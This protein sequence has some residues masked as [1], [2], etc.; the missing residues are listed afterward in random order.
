MKK[1]VLETAEFVE[2]GESKPTK[3]CYRQQ[4][5]MVL[6]TPENPQ[7]ADYEEMSKTLPMRKKF[8]D[9]KPGDAV[10][11][12]DAEHELLARR[13]KNARFG[14]NHDELFAMVASIVDAP[15]VKV[16]PV[17]ATG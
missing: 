1:V 15:D 13:M 5:L 2:E 4:I 12:E 11:L 10:I 17:E 3:I 9:A 8:D 6:R 7:G 14:V 16:E